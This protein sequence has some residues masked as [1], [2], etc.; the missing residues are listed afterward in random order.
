MQEII[1][2]EVP[3]GVVSVYDLDLRNKRIPF[4]GLQT[5]GPV[6]SCKRYYLGV[7]A[8]D[9]GWKVAF[10]R[11]NG[12]WNSYKDVEEAVHSIFKKNKAFTNKD[13]LYFF[14]SLSELATWYDSDP[15]KNR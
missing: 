13:Q 9:N 6:H 1:P 3:K 4:I 5:N 12:I 7:I 11:E 15:N 10:L 14:D 2:D 8:T